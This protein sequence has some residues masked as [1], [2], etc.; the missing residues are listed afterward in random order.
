MVNVNVTKRFHNDVAGIAKGSVVTEQAE[1]ASLDDAMNWGE[2]INAD[3]T[4]HDFHICGVVIDSKNFVMFDLSIVVN[5]IPG[6][7]DMPWIDLKTAA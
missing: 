3:V 6:Y 5:Q 1:F 2:A 7:D 4:K